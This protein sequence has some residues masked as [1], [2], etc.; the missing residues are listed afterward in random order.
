MAYARGGGKALSL[1]VSLTACLLKIYTMSLSLTV[2]EAN[3]S[4]SFS[5]PSNACQCVLW[6]NNVLGLIGGKKCWVWHILTTNVYVC[7]GY[8]RVR[9][10]VDALLCCCS[11]VISTTA[12]AGT[13]PVIEKVMGYVRMDNVVSLCFCWR[14]GWLGKRDTWSHSV[15]GFTD[16]AG[17]HSSW[18]SSKDVCGLAVDSSPYCLCTSC[19]QLQVSSSSQNAIVIPD[20]FSDS[21]FLCHSL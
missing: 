19:H 6:Y 8:R 21:V 20:G 17:K 1:F 3:H 18:L 15:T 12:L 16:C 2:F 14:A 4:P 10:W 11:L 5:F 7:P 9:M 13:R